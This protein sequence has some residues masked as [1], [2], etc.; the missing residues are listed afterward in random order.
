MIFL[1]LL[2]RLAEMVFV[3][4]SISV[5]VF[6]IF[7]ATP[8]ADP[9]ARIAGRGASPATLAATLSGWTSLCPCSTG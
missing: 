1:V 3:L 5:L 7:F 8:G 6:L 4:F 2:R 9:A